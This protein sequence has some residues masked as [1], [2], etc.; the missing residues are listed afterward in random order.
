MRGWLE[1]RQRFTG[2]GTTN[3][4]LKRVPR[5]VN[6]CLSVISLGLSITFRGSWKNVAFV[7]SQKGPQP[8][9]TS[10]S[11]QAGIPSGPSSCSVPG[12]HSS[13]G[14]TSQAAA[15]DAGGGGGDGDALRGGAA[16]DAVASRPS[17]DGWILWRP[18]ADG[19]RAGGGAGAGA[20]V[21]RCA[22]RYS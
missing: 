10:A 5:F 17:L 15:M 21:E 7:F 12:D 3:A 8:L 9:D 18:L 19:W 6:L 2:M 14:S 11:D 22:L 13:I 1:W 4:R 16:E 20:G